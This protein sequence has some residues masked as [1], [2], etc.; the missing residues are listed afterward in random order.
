[1]K[2]SKSHSEIIWPL[3][4]GFPDVISN[5]QLCNRITNNPTKLRGDLEWALTMN[6]QFLAGLDLGVWHQRILHFA[7]QFSTMH[8]TSGTQEQ[9]WQGPVVLCHLKIHNLINFVKL[10]H[11]IKLVSMARGGTFCALCFEMGFAGTF[12]GKQNRANN[13]LSTE[14]SLIKS[15]NCCINLE[16]IAMSVRK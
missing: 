3:K 12:L 11:C 5:K 15:S 8:F 7:G 2:T 16:I 1:M 9:G 6:L 10:L 4:T 14:N 13:I